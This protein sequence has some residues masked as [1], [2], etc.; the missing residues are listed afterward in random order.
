MMFLGAGDAAEHVRSGLIVPIGIASAERSALLPNVLPLAQQGLPG[1]NAVTWFGLV[2]PS[3]IPA[4]IANA[5]YENI[6]ARLG[7]PEI[8]ARLSQMGLDP[9]TMR[10]KEFGRFIAGE[11][12]KWGGVIRSV[13]IRID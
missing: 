8:R 7:Q 12:D 9:L 3:G 10:S 13:G 5:Y 1:F 11:V 2:G 4:N 6:S